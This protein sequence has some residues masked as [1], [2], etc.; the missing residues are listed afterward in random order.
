MNQTLKTMSKSAVLIGAILMAAPAMAQ[1]EIHL[2]PPVAFRATA[3]PVYYEGH[4]AYWYGGRWYYQSGRDWRS[5]DV[6][7]P[8]L[9]E[10]RAHGHEPRHY[11]RRHHHHGR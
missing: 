5:Y 3:T 6:E 1:I 2:F 7:P 11:E 10:W 4:A 9:R 8:H